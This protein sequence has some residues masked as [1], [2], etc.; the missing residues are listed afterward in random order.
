MKTGDL[1]YLKSHGPKM[2]IEKVIQKRSTEGGFDN[3]VA[4]ALSMAPHAKAGDFAVKWGD[5]SKNESAIIPKEAVTLICDQVPNK[6][7]DDF[8]LGSVVKSKLNDTIMT[9]TW[10]VGVTKNPDAIYDYNEILISQMGRKSG[11]FVCQWFEKNILKSGHFSIQ[12]LDKI[13]D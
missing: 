8:N 11:D 5:G 6:N 12:D 13:G 1:I 10:I 7:D 2:I 3:L 4:D 9:I